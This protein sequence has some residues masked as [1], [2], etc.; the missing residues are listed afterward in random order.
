[1]IS[2]NMGYNIT[3]ENARQM[4]ELSAEKKRQKKAAREKLMAIVDEVV[5][6]ITAPSEDLNELS[7]RVKKK[8]TSHG[9]RVWLNALSS[10]KTAYPAM[11][12]L[13]N[14]V[15]GK[16]KQEEPMQVD[17][18]TGGQAFTGFSSVLPSMPHIEEICA[19]IDAQREQNTEDE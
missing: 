8:R 15:V 12:D 11:Q 5:D 6:E 17:I 3:S 9:A 14:R 16:P 7:K 18:T 4:Q 2:K 1:M 10:P 19:E 13:M